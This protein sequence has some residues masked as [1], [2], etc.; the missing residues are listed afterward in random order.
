MR[1]TKIASGTVVLLL[2]LGAALS[3]CT[4][5]ASD[6]AFPYAYGAYG[7]DYYSDPAYLGG[8]PLYGE[9]DF[10][11]GCCGGFRHDHHDF[12]D[13]FAAHDGGHAFGHGGFGHAGFAH[14]G[15]GHG[16]GGGGHGR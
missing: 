7:A 10:E 2:S 13:H 15:F 11:G 6:E 4:A 9:F 14:G 16:G 12:H 5:T 3:A 1:H 8:A